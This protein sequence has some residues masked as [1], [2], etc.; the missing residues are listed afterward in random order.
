M[1]QKT[2]FVNRNPSRALRAGAVAAVLAAC[3]LLCVARGRAARTEKRSGGDLFTIAQVHYHGGGDWYEDKTAM[4]R[5][6]ERVQKEFGF[7]AANVR[8]VV[9]LTDEALFEYPMI[10]MCGH[11]NVEFSPEE[12][13]RLRTYLDQGG[14]LWASDD[15]GMDPAFRREMRKVYPDRALAEIPLSHDIYHI[16]HDFPRGL[17]KIHEHA[18]GPAHGYGIIDETG[19]LTVFYDFNTDI[20]DGLE[21]PEIHKD[22]AEKREAA[23]RMALNIVLYAMT[24]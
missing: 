10:Y 15:Y 16:Y 17:P 14:F 8:M 7:P 19:R 11:G 5:L 23:F 13:M 12:V 4:V 6:Q 3:L 21:A 9:E 2:R 22:P 20:G 18:G 24:H 1:M